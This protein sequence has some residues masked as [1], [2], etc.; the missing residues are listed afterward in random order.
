M[1]VKEHVS[2][3]FRREEELMRRRRQPRKPKEHA[4]DHDDVA[5]ESVQGKSNN[6]KS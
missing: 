3:V 1:G 2:R 6:S 5:V 4:E